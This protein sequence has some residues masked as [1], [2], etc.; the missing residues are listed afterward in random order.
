MAKSKFVRRQAQAN[1]TQRK[2]IDE[3]QRR[4]AIWIEEAT[5]SIVTAT[6]CNSLRAANIIDS[7]VKI[8][9]CRIYQDLAKRQVLSIEQVAALGEVLV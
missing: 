8:A 4:E 9:E 6:G 2:V 5:N 3:L 7:I 1:K